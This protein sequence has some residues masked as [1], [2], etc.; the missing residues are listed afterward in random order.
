MRVVPG[1]LGLELTTLLAIASVGSFVFFGLLSLV[2]DNERLRSDTRAFDVAS[3]IEMTWLDDVVKVF[4]HLGS[5]AVLVPVVFVA[6]VFLLSRRRITEGLVL[7]SGSV[8]TVIA[9]HVAKDA[10]DRPRPSD[11]LV[12]TTSASFPSAHAAYS[13]AYVAIAIALSHAFPRFVHRA[14]IVTAGIVL[15]AVIGFSRVYLRAHFLSDVLA[16]WGLGAAV[17]AVC[18]I[19]GLIVSAVRHNDPAAT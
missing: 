5:S 11:S 3:R 16:G 7:L 17:F 12:D 8:F 13:V 2:Q 15:A 19:V 18:G 4:T 1:P 10:V 14:V 9:V 6:V